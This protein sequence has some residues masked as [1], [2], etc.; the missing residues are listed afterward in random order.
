MDFYAELKE[1]A[2]EIADLKKSVGL[3][4][5]ILVGLGIGII[6]SFSLALMIRHF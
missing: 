5:G 2:K 6:L 1:S 4:M 3:Y